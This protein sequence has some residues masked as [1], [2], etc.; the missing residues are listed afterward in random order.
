MDNEKMI[1]EV[2]KEIKDETISKEELKV[3]LYNII[4]NYTVSK[5]QIE[6]Y[7]FS[8]IIKSY[9][10]DMASLN[11]SKNT[12]KNKMYTIKDMFRF[13]NKDIHNITLVDL[14]AYLNYKKENCKSSSVNSLITTIKT[15]F[16]WC[17]DEEYIEN[18]P[19]KKLKKIKQEYLIREPLSIENIERLRINCQ[20]DRER[21]LIEF[22]LSTG[23]RVSEI[24]R[25]NI[26][27]LNFDSNKLKILGKGNKERIV[28]F[29]DRSK[30]YLKEYLTN[31]KGIDDALF[32]S[33]KSPYRRLGIR[34]IQKI[35][36][37][38]SDRKNFT[39]HV[40]PHKL[41][42]TFATNMFHQGVDLKTVQFL[43]GHKSITT[44]QI[45]VKTNINDI[46]YK[47][48]KYFNI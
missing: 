45:Y 14:K 13:V 20:T 1:K 39:T 47:Y 21:A 11:Y 15:F 4:R 18:N 26:S 6:E 12:I 17:Y 29:N 16:T 3:I 5:N 33:E 41:R 34:A 23:M 46:T 28:L 10:I 40:F 32:T 24:Q 44:T 42:H 38:I 25:L 37:D 8:Q 48:N 31:R 22:L 7:D 2:L 43:L 9:A 27:D 30:L 36:K 19:S 35:L